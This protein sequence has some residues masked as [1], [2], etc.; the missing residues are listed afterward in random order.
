[1]ES[2]RD[3]PPA[4]ISKTI[5]LFHICKLI[6]T[7]LRFPEFD[8][9]YLPCFK[10]CA[11]VTAAGNINGILSRRTGGRGGAGHR[12]R[13][14]FQDRGVHCDVRQHCHIISKSPLPLR[15]VPVVAVSAITAAT[16]IWIIDGSI[17]SIGSTGSEMG[18][19]DTVNNTTGI[20]S[21]LTCGQERGR[22]VATVHLT[23][24][25]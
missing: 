19:D 2:E 21:D 10:Q 7:E 14:H 25:I 6:R 5:F 22:D 3:F 18:M 4:I 1:M 15:F 23:H 20:T 9:N 8:P 24:A 13:F 16:A 12:L 11:L 17:G